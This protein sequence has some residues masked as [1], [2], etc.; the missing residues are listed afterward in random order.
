MKKGTYKTK[1][2]SI[3]E[4]S[5]KHSGIFNIDWDWVEEDA[6]D[7]CEPDVDHLNERLVWYC[8]YCGGG[9]AELKAVDE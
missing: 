1:G 8:D 4:V 7:S 6:C 9:S 3:V 2:G 5:G